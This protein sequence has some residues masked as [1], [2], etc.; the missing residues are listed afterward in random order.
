MDEAACAA[1]ILNRMASPD[2]K[3]E[4]AEEIVKAEGQYAA[5]WDGNAHHDQ[6]LLDYLKSPSGQ[7]DI[8]NMLHRLQGRDSFKGTTERH[9]MG[10]GDVLVHEMGNFYHYSDQT[11][12]SGPYTGPKPTH[13]MKFLSQQ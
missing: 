7:R 8:I 10:P 2:W 11:P 9:N 1:N 3:G 12:N 5:M 4:T 6:K 13:Y